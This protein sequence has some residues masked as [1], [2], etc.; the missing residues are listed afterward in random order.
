VVDVTGREPKWYELIDRP[1]FLG[2]VSKAPKT[3]W[4]GMVPLPANLDGVRYVAA[5]D[6][7]AV[8]AEAL[9]AAA[10]EVKGEADREA[11]D[12][13]YALEKALKSHDWFAHYSDDNGVF[14]ASERHWDKIKALMAKVPP[15]VA[16]ALLDQYKPKV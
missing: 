11:S 16:E 3:G 14:F 7:K 10:A 15:A 5:S 1:D 12:P 4:G 13:A 9:R 2:L 6:E 8:A